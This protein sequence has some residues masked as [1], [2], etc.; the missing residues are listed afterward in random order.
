MSGFN[1]VRLQAESGEQTFS[2]GKSGPHDFQYLS[3][4]YEKQWKV[5]G[6]CLENL[7]TGPPENNKHFR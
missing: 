2:L 3:C 7:P 5:L 1:T 6:G 4:K